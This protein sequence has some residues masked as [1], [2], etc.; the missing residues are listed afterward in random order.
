MEYE[1]PLVLA[2]DFNVIPEP[3][4][5]AHPELWTSRRTVP[6]DRRGRSSAN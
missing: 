5:A 4:D 6:A 3:I 2:G 1:E